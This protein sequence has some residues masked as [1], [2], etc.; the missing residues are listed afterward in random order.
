MGAFAAIA[1]AFGAIV[2][3]LGPEGAS[4]LLQPVGKIAAPPG[5]PTVADARRSIAPSVLL[6]GSIRPAPLVGQRVFVDGR[7]RVVVQCGESC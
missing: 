4:R 2:I 3:A 1:F 6:G 5:E 7:A